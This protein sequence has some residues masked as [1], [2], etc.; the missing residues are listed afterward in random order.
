[1][2]R[3]L[4]I[5]RVLAVAGS[6]PGGGAGIQ[7]DLKTFQA[8]GVFGMAAVSALTSQ[9]TH[10]VNGVHTPPVDFLRRQME[11]VLEDL[12]ADVVKTGMLPSAAV[13]TGHHSAA[14]GCFGAPRGLKAGMLPSTVGRL[15]HEYSGANVHRQATQRGSA[16]RQSAWVHK[17]TGR[18]SSSAGCALAMTQLPEADRLLLVSQGIMPKAAVSSEVHGCL[19]RLAVKYN[20]SS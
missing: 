14:G 4:Q 17:C 6:D 8:R 9:N 11:S 10:G 18:L 5:P 1:M 15:S 2:H 7:A 19:H 12:G 13:S 3:C 16:A 20:T